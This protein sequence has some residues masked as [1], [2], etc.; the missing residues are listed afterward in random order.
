MNTKHTKTLQAI[1]AKPT[2]A[3]IISAEIESLLIALGANLTEREGSRVKFT[4]R[5]IEWHA[6][7]PHP[8]KEAKKYQIE[9]VRE[10]LSRLE[11]TL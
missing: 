6:H 5:G 3:S 4:L 8:G 10:I 2:R 7:R 1:F 9:Q 11:I